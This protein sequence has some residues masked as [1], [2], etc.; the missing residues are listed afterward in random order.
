[1]QYALDS[2]QDGRQSNDAQPMM[3]SLYHRHAATSLL[4]LL[5]C[6]RQ[7]SGA[8]TAQ[9]E[10]KLYEPE[11][12]SSSSTTFADYHALL[13]WYCSETA[14]GRKPDGQTLRTEI[15][16]TMKHRLSQPQKYYEGTGYVPGEDEGWRPDGVDWETY[17][18]YREE[19]NEAVQREQTEADGE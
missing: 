19:R 4:L 16:R 13:D 7:A 12:D 5:V 11:A 3:R 8:A 15:R 9:A 1:M 14:A 18:L 6:A 17:K 10:H 2:M